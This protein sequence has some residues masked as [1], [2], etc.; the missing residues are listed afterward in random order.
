MQPLDLSVPEVQG[1]RVLES[2]P[3]IPS[4]HALGEG[5]ALVAL[6]MKLRRSWPEARQTLLAL[7]YPEQTLERVKAGA[8]MLQEGEGARDDGAVVRGP[9]RGVRD[10]A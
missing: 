10:A 3:K 7:I 2:E 9:G 5:V 1:A 8:A 4:F 6:L